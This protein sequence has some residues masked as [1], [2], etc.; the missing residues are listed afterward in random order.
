MIGEHVEH[1]RYGRGQIVA[2]YRNGAEW[3]VRFE[4]GLRFR[5]ARQE[6]QGESALP[7]VAP[8]GFVPPA[9]MPRS[10][11]EARNLVEALRFGVAPA[12][13][14]HEL[15]IG[16]EGERASLIA[17]LNGAHGQGG[18]VRAVIGDYGHGKSHL[19]ELAAQEA[20]ARN[21]LV[22]TASLDLLE[23]PPHRSFDIYSSLVQSLRYPDGDERGLAP[24]L[25]RA[26]G[27]PRTL[28]QLAGLSALESD[29]LPLTLA[30]LAGSTSSRQRKAWQNWLMGGRRVAAMNRALPPGIK[31]PS[32]YKVGNNARQVAYL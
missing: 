9:P 6:F 24:L 31:F 25:D 13:Y 21:F 17:G 11:F 8:A 14:V 18:A 2:V 22:A 4:S 16:L 26:A 5:R 28:Q 12:H 30:A 27:E 10:R 7:L 20:L 29:P 19:V 23:L 1:P 3:L 15:T 32:I